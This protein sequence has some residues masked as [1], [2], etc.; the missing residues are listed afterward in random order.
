MPKPYDRENALRVLESF[1]LGYL[2]DT[3]RQAPENRGHVATML[4][5]DV[6]A[7]WLLGRAS[8]VREPLSTLLQWIEHANAVD[9]QFGVSP[10]CDAAH[11]NEAYGLGL[12][13]SNGVASPHAHRAAVEHWE[14]HFAVEGTRVK[15]GPP[16]F[17]YVAQRFEDPV[18]RGLPFEPADILKGSLADYLASCVQCGEFARGVE[19]YERVGGKT[20]LADARIQ[21]PVHFG[22]WLCKRGQAGIVPAVACAG[23]GARV[24]RANLPTNW[25][26]VGQF[27]RAAMWIKIVAAFGGWSMSPRDAMRRAHDELTPERVE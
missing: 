6:V 23:I 17:D 2:R 7:A 24:L 8:D 19:L 10:Q 3:C 18:V 26:G 20:D 27:V 5:A 16:K 12:W 22:Y 4:M 15:R 1:S 13:M 25:L 14:R 11:R 21:H 9:E